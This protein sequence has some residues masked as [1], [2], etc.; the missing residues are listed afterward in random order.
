MTGK[1]AERSAAK[2]WSKIKAF[3]FGVNAVLEEMPDVRYKYQKRNSKS[4]NIGPNLETVA[5][6]K[7]GGSDGNFDSAREIV[8]RSAP[9]KLPTIRSVK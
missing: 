3:E 9:K 8:E 5:D 1:S 6:S 2:R 7:I 4:T